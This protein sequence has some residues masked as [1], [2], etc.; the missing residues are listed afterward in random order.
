[1][2]C[3]GGKLPG[4][5]L[6]GITGFR[7]TKGLK[8]FRCTQCDYDLCEKCFNKYYDKNLSNNRG[9]CLFRNKYISEVHE[10][11]LIFLDKSAENGWACNGKFFP[12]K[13]LSGIILIKQKIYQDLD[14]NN[15]ILIYMKIV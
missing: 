3:D 2:D 4:G 1:M 15:A 11:P 5:C 14:A 7:Q 6:S 12:N 10:H 13:C 8:R 9:V